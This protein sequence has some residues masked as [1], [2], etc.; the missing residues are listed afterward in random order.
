MKKTI[1]ILALASLGLT[2]VHAGVR[3]GIN[4]GILGPVYVAP[5]P[6]VELPPMPAPI[7]ESAPPCPVQGYVR[8]GGSWGRPDNHWEWTRGHWGPPV[9]WH[10]ESRYYHGYHGEQHEGFYRGHDRH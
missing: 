9:V 4:F 5:A 6:V 10:R 2:T 1:A 3:V 8:V 7:V